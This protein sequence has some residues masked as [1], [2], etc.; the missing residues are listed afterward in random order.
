MKTRLINLFYVFCGLFALCSAIFICGDA[1]DDRD[2]EMTNLFFQYYRIEPES[3]LEELNAG[4]ANVFYPVIEEPP[5]SPLEQQPSVLWTQDDY[6]L[7]IN[8]LFQF[9]RDD[10]LTNGWQLHKMNFSSDC[11]RFEDGYY[12]GKFRFFKVVKTHEQEF[13]VER[14]VDIDLPDKV[15]LIVENKFYP[16]LADWSGIDLDEYFLS[17]GESLQIAE[18]N[19]GDQKRLSANNACYVDLFFNYRVGWRRKGWWWEVR[20]R[21]NDNNMPTLFSVDINPLTGEIRP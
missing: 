5:S 8:A 21:L 17:A 2:E 19:G 13:R 14:I 4:K 20:Y 12:D 1:L 6:F 9:A 3:I 18:K 16:I 7:I 11:E 15:I 10:T